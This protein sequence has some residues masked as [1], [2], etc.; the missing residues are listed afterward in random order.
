MRRAAR[1]YGEAKRP[2]MLHGLGVTEHL[3][4]SEAVTLLCN[5]ALLVGAALWIGGQNSGGYTLI[6]SPCPEQRLVHVHPDPE[7]LGRV[8][9][10]TLAINSGT[11]TISRLMLRKFGF[12]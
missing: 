6:A 2:M 10:A 5:L 11:G 4:G 3:Q 1:L 7:E 9:Q 8:Y 12:G